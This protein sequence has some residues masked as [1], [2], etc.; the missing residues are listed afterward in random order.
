VFCAEKEWIAISSE[1]LAKNERLRDRTQGSG[2]RFR[3]GSESRGSC[4][5]FPERTME[6]SEQRGLT[7]SPPEN[8]LKRVGEVHKAFPN[9]SQ[10]GCFQ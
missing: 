10:Y 7:M 6:S 1:G 5:T 4:R 3:S 8:L 9:L 2:A